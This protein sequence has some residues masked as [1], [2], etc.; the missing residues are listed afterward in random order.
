[1]RA[2]LAAIKAAY[3]SHHAIV[4][5]VIIVVIVVVSLKTHEEE[6]LKFNLP[7]PSH[8]KYHHKLQITT[9]THSISMIRLLANKTC[10]LMQTASTLISALVS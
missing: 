4:V 5:V 6:E 3:L 2:T 9:H 1:M 10:L 7:L 8:L